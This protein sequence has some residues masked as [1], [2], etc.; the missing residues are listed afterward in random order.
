[1]D[2]TQGGKSFIAQH[3]SVEKFAEG[4]LRTLV[5]ATRR[6]DASLSDDDV[7]AMSDEEIENHLTMIGV[8]GLA[9][10]L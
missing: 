9:D 6:L 2:E 3:D 8:S 7:R 5:F 10:R 4:G 1:M